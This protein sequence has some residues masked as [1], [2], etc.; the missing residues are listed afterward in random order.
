MG[1]RSDTHDAETEGAQLVLLRRLLRGV[2]ICGAG[3]QPGRRD[4]SDCD[5]LAGE[6]LRSLRLQLMRATYEPGARRDTGETPVPTLGCAGVEAT[7]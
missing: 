1:G 5:L 7:I 4:D 3:S 2:R 6:H